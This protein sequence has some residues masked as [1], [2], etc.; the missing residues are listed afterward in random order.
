MSSRSP[1]ALFLSLAV[2]LSA[3]AFADNWPAWRGPLGTGIC[4]EKNLPTTWSKTENVKWRVALPEP[5]NST[6]I[7]WNDRIFL[8]VNCSVA[9]FDKHIGTIRIL[10]N[11]LS[12]HFVANVITVRQTLG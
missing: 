1:I 8:T 5:G 3:N 7:V 4:E 9:M 10:S 12:N 6:P 2:V 11:I